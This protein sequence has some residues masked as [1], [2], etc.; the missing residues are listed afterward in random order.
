[1]KFDVAILNP[2]YLE[3][4]YISILSSIASHTDKLLFISPLSWLLNR[5]NSN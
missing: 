2:P 5:P 1:M 3:R 4:K